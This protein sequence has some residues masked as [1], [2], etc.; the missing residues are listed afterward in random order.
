M[1]TA[2]PAVNGKS[3]AGIVGFVTAIQISIFNIGRAAD[4]DFGVISTAICIAAVNVALYR[5][6][7]DVNGV[8]ISSAGG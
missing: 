7:A 8:I 6:A 5:T 3:V 4:D 1:R 2:A